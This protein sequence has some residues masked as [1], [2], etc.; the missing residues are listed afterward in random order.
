[1]WKRAHDVLSAYEYTET[2]IATVLAALGE[3]RR[4]LLKGLTRPTSLKEVGPFLL[5]VRQVNEL[6][7]EE[8][9]R[10]SGYW[11]R[12]VTKCELGEETPKRKQLPHLLAA[13]QLPDDVQHSVL[14]A[15]NDELNRELAAIPLPGSRTELLSFLAQIREKAELFLEDVARESGL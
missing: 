10:A 4:E 13:Y 5:A 9:A 3:E 1:P 12:S 15:I 7:L 8:V 11:K 2:E 14:T 6:S